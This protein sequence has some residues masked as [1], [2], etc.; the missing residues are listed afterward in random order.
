MMV[1]LNA[2]CTFFGRTRQAFYKRQQGALRT[3][4]QEQQ[5][6]AE[7]RRI[8]SKQPKVGGR[9]LLKDIQRL[10]FN[11]GRDRLFDILRKHGMLIKRKRSGPRTTYSNHWL[12]KYT[13]LVK[14][15]P[16]TGSNQVFVSDITYLRIASG[17]FAYLSLVTDAWSRKIV[18]WDVS[19]SLCVK[20]AIRALKMALKNVPH[21][22]GLIHH[23]D[24]GI[25]YCCKDYIK[26]LNDH[27]VLVSMTEE[28]HCYENAIAERL[29]G[30]LKDEFLLG[31]SLPSITVAKELTRESVNTYNNYRRHMNLDYQI[32]AEVH[33]ASTL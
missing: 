1:P 24:R 22:E 2:V 18:G 23:S 9:K 26:I 12:R 33:H 31:E 14:G 16:L 5:I 8:R 6:I 7:V 15:V 29:N 32:P 10:G 20:G 17:D 30:I 21:P 11:V 19:S 4:I 13:N 27:H 28:N 25:Q 3:F